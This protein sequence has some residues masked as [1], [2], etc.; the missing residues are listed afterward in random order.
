[1]LT[2]P[3]QRAFDEALGA[4]DAL[5]ALVNTVR[6]LLEQPGATRHQLLGALEEYRNSLRRGRRDADEDTVL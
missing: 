5:S 6:H 3:E 2:L 1:M 4:D